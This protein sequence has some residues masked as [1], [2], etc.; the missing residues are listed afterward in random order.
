MTKLAM[1]LMLMLM[2][3]ATGSNLVAQAPTL[4]DVTGQIDTYHV[5][6]NGKIDHF[7][8]K[9]TDGTTTTIVIDNPND[10]LDEEIEDV[11]DHQKTVKV[12]YTTDSNPVAN[13]H[14]YVGMTIL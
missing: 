6:Q 10:S 14:H 8:V 12:E 3:C 11:H 9:E 1:L 5:N 7:T 4:Q 2:M 13:T